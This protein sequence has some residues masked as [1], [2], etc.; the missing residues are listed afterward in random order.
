MY[1][2][3]ARATTKYSSV[4]THVPAI[5]GCIMDINK[6]C[7]CWSSF[8]MQTKLLALPLETVMAKF[9]MFVNPEQLNDGVLVKWAVLFS[10]SA[11]CGLPGFSKHVTFHH[12]MLRFLLRST[13]RVRI[14]W[15]FT[16]IFTPCCRHISL[17]LSFFFGG[18]RV[19]R[20]E[21]RMAKC[22][23]LISPVIG[24]WEGSLF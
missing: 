11:T 20:N 17:S 2:L 23:E 14:L 9:E 15:D 12:D 8:I 13:K 19:V 4:K 22:L 16:F 1:F 24:S 5:M 10:N 18:G 6:L 21:I 3:N 7:S